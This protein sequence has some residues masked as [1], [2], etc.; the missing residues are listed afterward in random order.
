MANEEDSVVHCPNPRCGLVFRPDPRIY[1]QGD[2]F[3]PA[4]GAD[5]EKPP[6][7]FRRD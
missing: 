2:K 6:P 3:C 4:C 1:R 5:L 7:I